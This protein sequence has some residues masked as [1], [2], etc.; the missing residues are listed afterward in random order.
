MSLKMADKSTLTTETMPGQAPRKPRTGLRVLILLVLV[1]AVAA[2]NYANLDF[3]FRMPTNTAEVEIPRSDANAEKTVSDQ[4]E[5][6]GDGREISPQGPNTAA[7]KNALPVQTATT[8]S[9]ASANATTP[10]GIKAGQVQQTPPAAAQNATTPAPNATRDQPGVQARSGSLVDLGDGRTAEV[11]AVIPPLTADS[12]VTPRFINDLAEFLINAYY[13]KG[14]HPAA[15]NS[16]ISTLG[17]KSLNLRYGGALVGLNKPVDDPAQRRKFVLGYVMMPSMIRAL[18]SLYIDTFISSLTRK[19]GELERTPRDGAP[20]KIS[21]REQAEMFNI[22]A[23]HTRTLAAIFRA[24]AAD[25]EI[26]RHMRAYW[27]AENATLD[28]DLAFQEAQEAHELTRSGGAGDPAAAKAKSD[29]AGLA[30]RDAVIK[31]ENAR[32]SLI[33]TLRGHPGVRGL[34]DDQ[35]LYAVAWVQRRLQ[36]TPNALNALDAISSML[37]NLAGRLTALGNAQ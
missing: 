33:S 14:T 31:R 15:T 30:Y 23:A 19:A 5:N 16:G 22:Y 27:D 37:D 17:L 7:T 24:C 32:S 13:P 1:G 18:Y 26:S 34:G 35:M 11:G 9:S 12:T 20:R 29:S 36:D 28:A 10:A 21:P 25:R 8:S 3:L 6:S 2:L 4:V